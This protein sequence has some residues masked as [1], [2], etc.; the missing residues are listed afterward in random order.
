MILFVKQREKQQDLSNKDKL[1]KL[2][3]SLSG[4]G[5]LRCSSSPLPPGNGSCRTGSTSE[6]PIYH[7]FMSN[8]IFCQIFDPSNSSSVELW[9]FLLLQRKSE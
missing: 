8:F 4:G 3:Q 5:V 1:N 7:S 6:N 2:V 9:R